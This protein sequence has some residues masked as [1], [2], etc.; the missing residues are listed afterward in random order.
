MPVTVT[1]PTPIPPPQISAKR[2]PTSSGQATWCLQPTHS[3]LF[4]QNQ[5]NLSSPSVLIWLESYW[6]KVGA[7][8]SSLSLLVLKLKYSDNCPRLS[9][10][11]STAVRWHLPRLIPM[12]STLPVTF[13][14]VTISPEILTYLLRRVLPLTDE[15]TET[16]ERSNDLPG[17]KASHWKCQIL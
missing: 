1:P 11:C 13:P 3:A 15:A 12:G 10:A 7:Y 17:T 4:T 9:L 14:Y 2:I 16:E 5:A 6:H 8:Q